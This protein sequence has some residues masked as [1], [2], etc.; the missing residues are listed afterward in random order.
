MTISL[1]ERFNVDFLELYFFLLPKVA[2]TFC[3]IEL[4]SEMKL[5]TT[6]RLKFTVEFITRLEII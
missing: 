6:M 4:Q 1:I 3:S 5:P 2:K